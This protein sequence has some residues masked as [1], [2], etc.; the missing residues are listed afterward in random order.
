MIPVA[1]DHA[2]DV[3]DRDLL[4][5]LVPNV[6]P[7]R[8][9]FENQQTQFVAGIEEVAGLRIMGCSD[10]VAPQILAQDARIA[11]LRAARHRLADER[12]CL[13]AVKAAQLNDPA[14]Q[15]EAVVRELR[16]PKTNRAA[17]LI[18]QL[19][20][21]QQ[22]RSDGIKIRVL[23]VPEFDPAEVVEVYGVRHRLRRG[24]RRWNALRCF[25]QDALALVK[26]NL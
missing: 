14:I 17:I 7:A 1:A 4:P 12:K 25:G 24:L 23:E 26:F 13:M 8:D 5:R 3:I 9:L 6:L 2:G 19:G 15:L 11:A 21:V 16:L 10:D 22:T 18:D 20:S